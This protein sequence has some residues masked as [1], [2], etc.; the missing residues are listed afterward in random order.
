LPIVILCDRQS[1]RGRECKVSK[2]IDPKDQIIG[3]ATNLALAEI[4]PQQALDNWIS[5]IKTK[6]IEATGPTISSKEFLQEEEQHLM[7]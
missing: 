3:V 4:K 6:M 7:K 2:I 5:C 1:K